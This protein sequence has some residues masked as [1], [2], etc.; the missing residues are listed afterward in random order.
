M[1]NKAKVTL[2]LSSNIVGDFNDKS[3]FL[4][5]LLLSNTQVSYTTFTN[6]SSA[7]TQ[8]HKIVQSGGILGRLLGPLLKGVLPLIGNLLKPL[9]KTVLITLRLY[10]AASATDTA[11]HKKIFGSG[12]TTLII[13]LEDI[14]K[15]VNSLEDFGLLMKGVH[16]TIEKENKKEDFSEC[17]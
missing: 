7:K 3:N 2:N 16:E 1:K 5:N 14:M 15:V 8:L 10:G 6:N 11:I 17:Y 13:S 12:F 9:A 4:H